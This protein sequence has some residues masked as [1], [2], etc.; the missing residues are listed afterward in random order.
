MLIS[1]LKIILIIHKNCVDFEKAYGE[2]MTTKKAVTDFLNNK[3]IAVVGVSHN[4]KK[5]GYAWFD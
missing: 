5:F 3:S 1:G 4:P 2:N